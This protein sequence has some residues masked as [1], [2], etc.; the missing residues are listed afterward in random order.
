MTDEN[1]KAADARAKSADGAEKTE[2]SLIKMASKDLSQ[3]VPH[4]ISATRFSI[5]GFKACFRHEMAFRQEMLIGLAN[6]VAVAVLPL[7]VPTRYAMIVIWLVLICAELLNSAVEA[8]VDLVS[9]ERHPLAKRAKDCGSAAVFC[10]LVAF[11]GD[12]GII[13]VGLLRDLLRR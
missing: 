13:A 4:M 12:W 2:G 8:V 10:V 11:F 9:P 7:K 5:D 3:G 6:L 1:D